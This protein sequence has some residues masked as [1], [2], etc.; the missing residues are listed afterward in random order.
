M[1]Q[2]HSEFSMQIVVCL[3]EVNFEV[4]DESEQSLQVGVLQ[5]DA[6]DGIDGVP[7]DGGNGDRF[8]L[9][10]PMDW[11][12]HLLGCFQGGQHLLVQDLV[13]SAHLY[14][15]NH[16]LKVTKGKIRTH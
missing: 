14:L 13:M 10:C 2:G 9:L 5:R 7:G 8:G 12:L 3:L 15:L 11:W 1:E 16:L 4:K 6:F